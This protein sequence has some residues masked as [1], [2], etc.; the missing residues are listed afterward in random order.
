MLALRR[1]GARE[2]VAG[3]PIDGRC[4]VISRMDSDGT[5]AVDR[6]EDGQLGR[7]VGGLDQPVNASARAHYPVRTGFAWLRERALGKP[8]RVPSTCASL[9]SCSDR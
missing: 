1:P 2:V 5:A 3:T 7:S 9:S 6:A 8:D 4:R